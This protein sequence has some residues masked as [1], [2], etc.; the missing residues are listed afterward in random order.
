MGLRISGKSTDFADGAGV[1]NAMAA[2][3]VGPIN[4]LLT[5]MGEPT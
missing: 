5:A 2:G 1:H 4:A 3:D